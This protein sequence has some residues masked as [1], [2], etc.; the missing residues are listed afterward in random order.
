[1]HCVMHDPSM[2]MRIS[3]SAARDVSLLLCTVPSICLYCNPSMSKHAFVRARSIGLAPHTR[4]LLQVG[5]VPPWA[6]K[7]FAWLC[8][9]RLAWLCV[10]CSLLQSCIAAK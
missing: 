4:S 1:M 8:V 5:P 9:V 2:C 6:H 7:W 3:N 10:L